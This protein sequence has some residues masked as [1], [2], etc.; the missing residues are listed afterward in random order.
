M[1]DLTQRFRGLDQIDAPDVWPDATTRQTVVPNEPSLGRR[2][3]VIAFAAVIAFASFA[4][5]AVAFREAGQTPGSDASPSSGM[6]ESGGSYVLSDLSVRFLPRGPDSPFPDEDRTPVAFVPYRWSWTTETF[7]GEAQCEVHLFAKSGA[8]VTVY[9]TGF[10]AFEP[11]GEGR[12]GIEVSDG[13]PVRAVA[14]CGPGMVFAGSSYVFSDLRIEGDQVFGDVGWSSGTPVGY[15][16]CAVLIIEPGGEGTIKT[17]GLSVGQGTDMPITP[18]ILGSV[19]PASV[20]EIRCEQYRSPAQHENGYWLP[21]EK[22]GASAEAPTDAVQS[23]PPSMYVFTDIQVGPSAAEPQDL[24]VT[25][26]V[27]WTGDVYPGVHRCGYRALAA[28]ESVVGEQVR[29]EAW[30]PGRWDHEVPGDPE[31]AVS[32]EVWCEPERLDTPGVADGIT[33]VLPGDVDLET[34]E[35]TWEE[36]LQEMKGRLHE[37]ASAYSVDSMSEDELAANMVAL[38][39]AINFRDGQQHF[40]VTR[41][42]TDRR[43]YLCVLLPDGHE[44][45]GGEYCD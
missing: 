12:F 21:W 8:L 19:P 4:M 6:V 31:A 36:V 26:T 27:A 15:S 18:H 39:L 10:G 16:A 42:L 44:F 2:L 40:T 35:G 24:A 29:L 28:D 32:G 11:T 3:G 22:Q 41:Q 9:E 17:F 30:Q 13:V 25:F 38:T 5:I 33:P 37:W 1:D 43:D 45:R 7:P 20:P 14:Q 34:V 23:E